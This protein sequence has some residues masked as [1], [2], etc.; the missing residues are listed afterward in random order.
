MMDI[1]NS[2][3]KGKLSEA[4]ENTNILSLGEM[5]TILYACLFFYHF[6]NG[7]RLYNSQPRSLGLPV[8]IRDEIELSLLI[9]R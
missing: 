7:M 5:I 4:A 8:M 2:T 3:V 1:S 6:K 9:S